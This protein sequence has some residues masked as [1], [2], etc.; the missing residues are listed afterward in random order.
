MVQLI[1]LTC[2]FGLFFRSK[3]AHENYKNT[4][5]CTG[6]ILVLVKFT[7]FYSITIQ[8]I[9]LKPVELVGLYHIGNK[10]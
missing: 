10:S 5:L 7:R 4:L 3:T 8:Y 1:S 6:N 2:A 9:I